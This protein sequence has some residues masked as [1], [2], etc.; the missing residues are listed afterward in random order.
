MIIIKYI[1]IFLIF[2]ISMLIGNL[3]S[4]KYILRTEELKEFK[5]ILNIIKNK[6]EFTYEPLPEI[7]NEVACLSDNNISKIFFNASANMKNLNAQEAWNMSLDRAKTNLNKEDIQNIKTL[8]KTLGQTDK[9]GQI[10]SIEVTNS[11]IE[12]QISKAKKEEEK[13]SKMYKTLG[14]IVGM[15]FVIILI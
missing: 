14:I 3:I 8:G 11:F 12:M 5:G 1:I 6:I 15:A 7:F 13:N 9:D 4:K 2:L 10:S